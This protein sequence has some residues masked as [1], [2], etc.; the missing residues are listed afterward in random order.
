MTISI[1]QLNI[2]MLSDENEHLDF[3]EA[4]ENYSLEKLAKYCVAFANEGGG[5]LILGVTDKKPRQ[6]VGTNAYK[7]VVHTSHAIYDRLHF[8]VDIQVIEHP[9]GRVLAFVV[10]SRPM[11]VPIEFN[12]QYLMR[13]GDSLVPMTQESIKM[14]FDESRPDF[15]AQICL[16]ASLS[17]LDLAAIETFRKMWIRKSGNN[18]LQHLSVD[19][20]LADAELC[21]D[22]GITY[23]ALILFGTR[24]TLGRYLPQSEIVFEYRSTE[25]SIQYQQRMEYRE[26]FFRLFDDLWEKI[27]LRND[28]QQFSEGFAVWDIPTFN[29]SVVREAVLNAVAHRDYS[30]P[31]SVFIR[32]YPRYLEVISPGGLLPGITPENIMKRHAPRN[33]RIAESFSRC[34]LVERSG[35]G[36]D[37]MIRESIK[38]SK[39]TPDFTETDNHQVFLTLRGDV[40]DP[41]F[42]RFLEKLGKERLTSFSTDDLMILNELHKEHPIADNMKQRLPMLIKQGIV[43][44]LGYGKGVRYILSHQFYKH[45]GERGS[46]TRQRGLDHNT[47]KAL[48]LSHISSCGNEG[49][50]LKELRQVL[51]TLSKDQVQSLLR[52]LKT[53]H[54]VVMEGKTS[55][56]KWMLPNSSI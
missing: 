6:V 53:D 33:R 15:S 55:A 8:R 26:G 31:G 23:A 22:G 35:Q 24:T 36:V 56:A 44:R 16:K 43:E 12:G 46:Y 7:D 2:W 34:G 42:L 40:Q 10:P 28:V 41:Q 50:Q 5:Y 52:E 18:S 11:G 9:N 29:E 54:E 30:Y 13:S 48:L 32:Q 21:V 1:D 45:L 3:K 20:L 39:P 17:D 4:R 38:E 27:S 37:K 49:C 47:N 25:A 14:I 51:P 19:Q